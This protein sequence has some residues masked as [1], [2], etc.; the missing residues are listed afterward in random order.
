MIPSWQG[1]LASAARLLTLEGELHIVDFGE[2]EQ[3]PK[4]FRA[5]LRAWLAKFHVTPRAQMR[6]VVEQLARQ[7]GAAVTFV[8]IKGGYAWRLTLKKRAGEVPAA[9]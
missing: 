2:Q 9:A 3:L 5:T 6:D 4:A 7:D 1:V 8:P